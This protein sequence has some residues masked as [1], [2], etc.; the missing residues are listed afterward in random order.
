[1]KIFA[2]ILTIPTI[3]VIT[4]IR[5]AGPINPIKGNTAFKVQCQKVADLEYVIFGG[6][7]PNWTNVVHDVGCKSSRS[8]RINYPCCIY[9]TGKVGRIPRVRYTAGAYP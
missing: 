3:V 9:S 8:F 2:E 7:I 1:M 6:T 5:F 4:E